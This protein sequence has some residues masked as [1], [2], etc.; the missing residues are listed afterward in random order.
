MP[1]FRSPSP[2]PVPRSMKHSRGWMPVLAGLLGLFALMGCSPAPDAETEKTSEDG[3]R[4]E[5]AAPPPPSESDVVLSDANRTQPGAEAARWLYYRHPEADAVRVSG[6]WDGW[7]AKSDMI[8]VQDG[9]WAFEIGNV[10]APFGRYEFKFIIDGEWE[11]GANRVLTLNEESQMEKPPEVVSQVRIEDPYTIRV[12]LLEPP[13]DRS[14]VEVELMPDLGRVRLQWRAPRI[15]PKTAGYRMRGA[16]VEF[17]FDPET[18]GMAPRAV[19]S[20]V[21]AGTFSGWN[22]E[23]EEFQLQRQPDGMWTRRVSYDFLDTKT[24]EE[25][26]MFKFVVNGEWKNPPDTAP[27]IMREPG[28]PHLNLSLPS[29]GGA[30]PEL[31]VI[32]SKPIDLRDPP[33]LTLRGLHPRTLKTRP[34]PGAILDT[35][36]SPAP[37][38]VT[39]DKENNRTIYRIFAPRALSVHL[40]QFA[41][42]YHTLEDKSPVEPD[43]RIAMTRR[44]DGAWEHVADGLQIGQYYAFQIDGP[45]GDGEGFHPGAWV[46]D[47]YAKAVSLAEGNSIVMDM[48][49]QPVQPEPRPRV[50]WEDMVIYETHVRHFTQHPSSGVPDELRG[51]Y[52][53]VLATRGT[54]AGLDHLKELGVNVVQFMPVHEFNNGFDGAHNWGYATCFFFAP[55]SSYATRPR[56]GSQVAEFKQL[57]DELH[58]EG[59]AVFLD[60]VYNHV[61]GINVFNRIDRKYYFRLNADL[62]NQNFSGVGNDVASERPMVRRLIRESVLFWVEEYGIDGFRFD[63]GE[64]TDDETLRQIEAEIREKHPH[65]VL[66]SEPWSFRGHHKDFLGGT[67]WGAW[68]D[69]FREPAKRFVSGRGDVDN[70]KKAIRGSVESWTSHPLQS[71][72]YME[73]HDDHSLT[74]ELSANPDLDGRELTARD[75]RIHKL[76]ATL[77]FASLGTPM[78]TEGQAYLRSKHGIRNTYNRGDAL[79]ALRWDERERPHARETLDYYKQMIAFRL[80]D[81]GRAL[82]TAEAPSLEYTRFF[83]S[84]AGDAL[85]WMV[86]AN[87]ERPDVPAVMVL[88]NAGGA[89]HTFEVELPPGAWRKIGDG[90]TVRA[91]GV[92]ESAT[93]G[94]GRELSITVPAQTAWLYRNGF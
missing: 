47:P 15:D 58:R 10:E 14:D 64:L 61:G 84:G 68:N 39:L 40:G 53:G 85:G 93:V 72:N 9:V 60:V 36:A 76:A 4:A 43:Q 7:E 91:G 78:I 77:I 5:D 21:V 2:I 27:N 41:G 88:M 32:T 19:R 42:P 28:T 23:H 56:E 12:L 51:T 80:S 87:G 46:G 38:G 25:H 71:V 63:L 49:A 54:G 26:P 45:P 18:Y 30:L 62:T 44:E 70:L 79:N 90:E 69:Q 1:N 11:G 83:D 8:T 65:V 82:R 81:A 55:E 20:A 86:N 37:M 57:V 3:T 33:V 74:D 50:A 94:G 29:G 66:H 75:E 89:P 13:A 22:P 6:S 16:E 67:S 31:R 35:L 52:P 17:V 73:S 92:P 59:F 48:D 24:A 34:T